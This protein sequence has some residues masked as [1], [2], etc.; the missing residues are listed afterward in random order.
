MRLLAD[1]HSH[2]VASGHAYSTVTENARA[3]A[4]KGLELIAITDH[5]PNV[6]Q[7]AHPWYFWNSKAVPQ[8]VCGVRV[9]KGCEAD[10]ADTD[11][12]IDLPDVVL[13]VLDFVAVGFHPMC[14]FD[15]RDRDRNTEAMLRVLANPL[16]DMI[17]HP[18]NEEEFPLHLDRVVDAA[19]R[20]GVIL[21]INDHSFDPS[22]VRS[23]SRAREIEFAQ[24][25]FD[26]G[27]AIAVNSDAHYHDLIGGLDRALEVVEQIGITEDRIVNRSAASVLEHLLAR[28]PRPRL[29][30]GGAE[31]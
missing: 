28:R 20:A 2:T 7:G 29:D 23:R 26:V 10:V 13:E 18:G 4:D 3:A 22:S 27:C 25:A 8:F 5:G 19:V 9:L 12:G 1:L 15:K 21:E 17:T 31:G 11:N 16:V 24:A 6:P 30:V 14:G